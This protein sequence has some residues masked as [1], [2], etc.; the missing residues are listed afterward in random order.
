MWESAELSRAALP[1]PHLCPLPPRLGLTGGQ[2]PCHVVTVMK[3]WWGMSDALSV[4]GVFFVSQLLPQ[5]SRLQLRS[6]RPCKCPPSS[7]AASMNLEWTFLYHHSPLRPSARNVITTP[8]L[9]LI[10]RRAK[11]GNPVSQHPDAH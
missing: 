2:T 4:P 11:E 3:L 9:A 10:P 6:S 8:R 1:F 5:Y 7:T